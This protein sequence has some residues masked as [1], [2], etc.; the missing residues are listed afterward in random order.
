MI[1]LQMLS[2]CLN[3]LQEIFG[4]YQVCIEWLNYPH[5]SLSKS[6]MEALSDGDSEL[7]L[8]ILEKMKSANLS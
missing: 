1:D 4:D 6:P 8:K 3:R 7:V 5:P 2:I